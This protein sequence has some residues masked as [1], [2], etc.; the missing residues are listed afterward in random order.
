MKTLTLLLLLFVYQLSNAQTLRAKVVDENNKPLS[1][2]TVYFDGTTRGVITD[3]EGF[4]DIEVPSR[5]SNPV[6]VISYLGYESLYIENF[7]TLK[8]VYRL[9]PK[10][11]NLDNVEVYTDLFTREQM[12]RVFIKYFI[13]EGS[14]ARQTKILN[15]DDVTLYYVGKEKTLY[16]RA[17]Y[18]LEIENEYLGYHVK[19]DLTD[20]EVNFRRKSLSD[21]FLKQT[22]YAGTTFFTD[23]DSKKKNNREKVYKKSLTSFFKQL[24]D[25][26]LYKTDFKLAHKGLLRNPHDVFNVTKPLDPS[27]N[28][29]RLELKPEY[30]DLVNGKYV[31]TKLLLINK[32]QRTT[33]MFKKPKFRIDRLGNL[34]DIKDVVLSNGLADDRVAKMLPLGYQPSQ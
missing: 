2:A 3:F 10:A 32:A 14:P 31:Y 7:N 18:P 27:V 21:N 9:K 17:L 12:E 20:F 13:G 26:T 4:F 19:F 30:I 5:V 29:I 6:L 8:P 24:A 33:L 16:A 25:S 28:L 1:S 23:V 34:I 11:E 15:L 22:F